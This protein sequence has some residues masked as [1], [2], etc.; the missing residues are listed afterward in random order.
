M[1]LFETIYYMEYKYHQVPLDYGEINDTA[2]QAF[3]EKRT[4]IKDIGEDEY[5]FKDGK[6]YKRG[7]KYK[8]FFG[9]MSLRHKLIRMGRMKGK[10]Y[11]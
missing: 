7:K 5:L 3:K 6:A 1:S 2:L 11:R 8:N 4:I 9:T 10:L